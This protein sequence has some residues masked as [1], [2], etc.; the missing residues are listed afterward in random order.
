MKTLIIEDEYPAA[1]RLQSLI[2]KLRPDIEILNILDSVEASCKWLHTHAAPDLIFSDIQLS[3]GLSFEIYE[4]VRP[5]SPIIFTTA[6]D[7]YAIK[8][9][10]VQ[11]VDYL[12]K[13]IKPTELEEAIGKYERMRDSFTSHEA[14]EKLDSLLQLL[15]PSQERRKYKNRFLIKSKD[16]YI[17]VQENEI[18]YFFTAHEMVYL[19][20]HDGKKHA[21]DFNLEQLAE[22]LDPEKFFRLNRQYITSLNAIH[23]IHPYFNGRLKLQLEPETEEDII[24]SRDKAKAFRYWMGEEV[25]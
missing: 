10:K 15:N 11:S 6:Y 8:A 16:Q 17:P 1:E 20:K 5:N 2:L 23:S 25:I 3:D 4:K 21:V 9:F 18:A 7:E 14:Q 19:I 24:V 22:I 13:P 12:L